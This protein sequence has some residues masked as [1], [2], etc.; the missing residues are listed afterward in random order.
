[1]TTCYDCNAS[2]HT[3]IFRFGGSLKYDPQRQEYQH[4]CDMLMIDSTKLNAID[5]RSTIDSYFCSI[6]TTLLGVS[7]F[8]E[9]SDFTV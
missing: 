5:N 8:D 3:V 9:Y 4:R 2:E 6:P 1:M 7:P